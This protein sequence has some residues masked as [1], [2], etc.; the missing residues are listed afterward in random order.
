MTDDI[1]REALRGPWQAILTAGTDTWD[2]YADALED[3]GSD[4]D[5]EVEISVVRGTAAPEEGGRAARSPHSGDVAYVVECYLVDDDDPSCGAEARMA[6][7][8]AMAAGLNAAA[9]ARED[10][11]S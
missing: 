11:P 4:Y 5:E 2:N 7:A 9:T 6:Q 1:T 10:Q 3:F 8:V